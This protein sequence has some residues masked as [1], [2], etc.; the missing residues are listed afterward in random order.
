MVAVKRSIFV[1][2]SGR[3]YLLVTKR[4][5]SFRLQ[6]SL[7]QLAD[8]LNIHFLRVYVAREV[9]TEE[10]RPR[11]VKM[12]VSWQSSTKRCNLMNWQ[13]KQI[14]KSVSC[15]PFFYP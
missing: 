4:N 11:K 8:G 2:A 6:T 14:S 7:G 9:L 10:R 15:L 1:S 13:T 12:L 3:K 5:G